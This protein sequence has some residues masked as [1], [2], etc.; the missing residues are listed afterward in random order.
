MSDA[1]PE[2]EAGSK[3]EAAAEQA[4][5]PAAIEVIEQVT[6]LLRTLEPDKR[7]RVLSI[8]Q[9]AVQYQGPL[10]PPEMMRGYN[11][12]I[13]NGANRIMELLEKQTDHR[14]EMENKVVT[15]K[16]SLSKT[17]QTLGFILALVFG[18][19]ALVF[20]LNGQPVLAGTVLTT[21]ILGLVGVFVL[22]KESNGKDRQ[23]PPPP[24]PSPPRKTPQ[25]K[26]KR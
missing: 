10:P 16:L 4:P 9:T 26:R 2:D 14:I 3:P 19:I 17:G 1:A 6:P 22:G 12:E 11:A 20:G 24:P 25:H 21:T 8:V 15:G 13:P 23:E 7:E 5:T 18:V